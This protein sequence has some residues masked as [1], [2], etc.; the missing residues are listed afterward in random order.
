MVVHNGTIDNKRLG[1]FLERNAKGLT[2]D[3]QWQLPA[4]DYIEYCLPLPLCS[5]TAS[6]LF[7][8]YFV[9]LTF[10]LCCSCWLC[11]FDIPSLHCSLQAYGWKFVKWNVL[12]IVFKKWKMDDDD[13]YWNSSE[14]K[15]SALSFDDDIVSDERKLFWSIT[16]N[17]FI[18]SLR[19]SIAM[20][21]IDLSPCDLQQAIRSF[22]L[23]FNKLRLQEAASQVGSA[24]EPIMGKRFLSGSCI[25]ALILSL[26]WQGKLDFQYNVFLTLIHKIWYRTNL[27]TLT[28]QLSTQEILAIGQQSIPSSQST[29][30]VFSISTV[31][32]QLLPISSVVKSRVLDLSECFLMVLFYW[33]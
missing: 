28:F 31:N 11:C 33:L 30:D 23:K 27:K 4:T 21:D 26:H 19:S 2:C 16:P 17:I 13:D 8:V 1:S 9:C 7:V 32:P 14:T 15:A 18:I 29:S 5:V 25:V 6:C 12:S 10:M 20:L 24:K 22:S 3:W